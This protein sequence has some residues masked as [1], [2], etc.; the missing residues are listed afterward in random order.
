MEYKKRENKAFIVYNG[1][2]YNF[3][4]LKEELLEKGYKFK[5]KTDTEVLLASYLEWGFECVKRFNGMWSFCIYDPRRNIL[6]CSRD[7]LG[8][9]PFYYYYY[10]DKFIFSSELKGILEHKELKL[11][12]IRNLNY[13]AIKLYFSLGF[14][15]SPYSIYKNV[16]KLEARENLIF[17]LKNKKIKKWY[18][19]EFPNFE[20]VYNKN[21]LI[22]R[23]REILN[24]AV[25]LRMIADVPIGAFLSGGIDSTTIVGEM[26]NFTPLTNLNTFSIGFHGVFD[27][28]NFISIAKNEFKT[29]HHHHFF[30]KGDFKEL[31]DKFSFIYDEPFADYSGFPTYKVS[32]LAK[33]NVKVCLSGDGGDE[34]FG[35]YK[36]YKSFYRI[37]KM[38][39]IPERLMKLF[40]KFIPK[41]FILEKDFMKMVYFFKDISSRI[42][43]KYSYAPDIYRKWLFKRFSQIFKD[44]GGSFT[45]LMI[46][47]DLFFNTLGD[48][49]LVKVDRASMNN[50]LEVRSPFLDYRFIEF[51]TKIPLKWK[52]NLFNTK[53]LLKNI[54]K[55][56]VPK[57]IINRKKQGFVPPLKKWIIE[58]DKINFNSILN[59]I[60]KDKIIQKPLF[61]YLKKILSNSDKSFKQFTTKYK[62]RLFL[63][64][65]WVNFWIK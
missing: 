2:I 55:D 33:K 21:L 64:Y 5:S 23:G 4:E 46:N 54:A 16:Y 27:E 61:N 44:S 1:E 42:I 11:N 19:Y 40:F 41:K 56:K 60:F 28:S 43:S 10:E 53:I 15:P 17:D 8:Q 57:E 36:R 49:F 18:Y 14:I 6:F 58:D 62:I 65:K 29:Q 35:G 52:V 32:E 22:K 7:R 39:T 9:K 51:S 12:R 50:G 34:I 13:Q 59:K 3:K 48:N 20:P 45:N 24:D 63:F 38:Q 25:R 26:K 47:L 30:K 37:E 31:I